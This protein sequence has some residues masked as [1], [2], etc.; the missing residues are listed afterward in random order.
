MPAL[1][2]HKTINHNL[3]SGSTIT[4]HLNQQIGEQIYRRDAAEGGAAAAGGHGRQ[5]IPGRH[6]A[7]VRGGAGHGGGHP[8]AA[9]AAARLPGAASCLGL[10]LPQQAL[11]GP[12]AHRL[13]HAIFGSYLA[14]VSAA[15]RPVSGVT[16]GA[17]RAKH[18]QESGVQ[19]LGLT[20]KL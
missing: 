1:R 9:Q 19:M 4:L 7:A 8:A 11:L 15:D 13:H 20:L 3:K 14:A 6:Q 10:A 12:C 17:S 18:M 2:A 5:R 16:Q